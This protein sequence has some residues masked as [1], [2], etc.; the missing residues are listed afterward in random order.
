MF[1][2]ITYDITDNNRRSHIA[3]IM[4]DYGT[5]VQYSVFECNLEKKSLNRLK[6][7]LNNHIDPKNDSIRIYYICSED[8]NKII[9]YGQGEVTEEDDV[10]VI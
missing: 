5:R 8:K 10:F 9:V 4:K 6:E 7:S 3:R 1:L 2:V